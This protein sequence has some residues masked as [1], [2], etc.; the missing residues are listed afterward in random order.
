MNYFI[1]LLLSSKFDPALSLA[2]KGVLHLMH[3]YSWQEEEKGYAM[4]HT[5]SLE[6]QIKHMIPLSQY[7]K[8]NKPAS[9]FY[10]I[11]GVKHSL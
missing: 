6:S 9:T 8:L 10:K 3:S 5:V 7:S 2:H 11:L 4:L 1:S